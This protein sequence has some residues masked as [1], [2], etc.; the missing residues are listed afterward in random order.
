MSSILSRLCRLPGIESSHEE[1]SQKPLK[2]NSGSGGVSA[3]ADE[4]SRLSASTELL[5]WMASQLTEISTD[6]RDSVDHVCGGFRGMADKAAKTVTIATE[7]IGAGKV[8]VENHSSE[9]SGAFTSTPSEWSQLTSANS[10][11]QSR[12]STIEGNLSLIHGALT[13][14]EYIARSAKLV[15][16]NGSIEATR[17]GSNGAAF[18]VVAKETKHLAAHAAQASDDIR[19][20]LECMHQQIRDAMSRTEQISKSLSADIGN[21]TLGMQFQDRVNQ[22]IEHIVSAMMMLSDRI[23]P[24]PKRVSGSIRQK[25]LDEWT[26]EIGATSTMDAERPGSF[27]LDRG[28]PNSSGTAQNAP[29]SIELF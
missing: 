17:A 15:A 2:S 27:G 1:S 19:G 3:A 22:R 23:E 8:S 11:A 25:Y 20:S 29:G 5:R 24:A 6:I 7:M 10:T 21:C 12:P 26:E 9:F 16:L 28:N 4:A 14:I 13:R 18:N